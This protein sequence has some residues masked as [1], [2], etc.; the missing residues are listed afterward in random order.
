VSLQVKKIFSK[1]KIIILIVIFLILGCITF[2]LCNAINHGNKN[3]DTSLNEENTTMSTGGSTMMST[4]DTTEEN[5]KEYSDVKD[6]IAKY[7]KDISNLDTEDLKENEKTTETQE[8]VLNMKSTIDKHFLSIKQAKEQKQKEKEKLLK[9]QQEAKAKKEAEEKAR[10]Q[11]AQATKTS[12]KSISSEER[13][14]LERLVEAEAGGEPY[15]GKLAVATV[16]MNRVNS[17]K[18]PNTVRGVIYQKNQFSPVA[19]RGLNRKASAE[20]KK[21]V[22]KVVDKG[23][24]SFSADVVYF[25]NPDIA[26]SKWIIK[27]RTFVTSVGNHDF[28]K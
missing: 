22:R 6:I 2:A 18:F 13:D 15:E 24:R 16:V 8:I 11:A 14:L 9:E 28:Y 26:T 23:Y 4:T 10:Q 25:L 20:T 21:A 7:S 17:S 12:S 27:N 19:N 5:E 3:T 1:D